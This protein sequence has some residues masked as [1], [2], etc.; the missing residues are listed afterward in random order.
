MPTRVFGWI[1]VTL[2]LIYKFPQIYKLWKTQDT[3][4]ISVYS[5]IV[6]A[7]AYG[8]YIVHGLLI[9]DPPVVV[10]G[11]TS[12]SQSLVLVAQFFYYRNS[13]VSRGLAPSA[14]IPEIVEGRE[15]LG[16]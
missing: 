4:G 11:I 7:S 14:V 15:D 13:K 12:L 16:R 2:S 3:R 9:E 5:Q 8:F 6:Q 1:A 10:L